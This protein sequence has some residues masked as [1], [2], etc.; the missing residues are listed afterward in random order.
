M[1]K[2]ELEEL[3]EKLEDKKTKSGWDTND[4]SAHGTYTRMLIELE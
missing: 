1:S 2:R 4:V 3:I